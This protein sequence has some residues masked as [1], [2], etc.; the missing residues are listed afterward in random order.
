MEEGLWEF[1]GRAL[2][3]VQL[4]LAVVGCEANPNHLAQQIA[5]GR[6]RGQVSGGGGG[7]VLPG[8]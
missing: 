2:G 8:A 4:Y 7:Q 5:W 3:Q 6:S 1:L